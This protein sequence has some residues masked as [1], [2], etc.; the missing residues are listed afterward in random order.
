M[1]EKRSPA[2]GRVKGKIRTWNDDKGFGFIEPMLGG[3]QVFIHIK[4]L[5][6]RQ[7]RPAVG[8]VVTY[9]LSSDRQ[10]RPCAVK[11][12]LAGDKPTSKPQ[13]KRKSASTNSG[14]SRPLLVGLVFIGLVA[15][16][17]TLGKLPPLVLLLYIG[18]SLLT[19]LFYYLDKSAA[20]AGNWRTKES[21][22]H[23]MSLLG[24]WPGAWLAQQK[25]RHKSRKQPFRF[26]FWLTVLA[27]IGALVWLHTADGS[28]HLSMLLGSHSS[29]P[30]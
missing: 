3:K 12:A 29:F 15:A 8:E 7:R 23:L 18:M 21:T 4:A 28:A 9:E 11:A 14:N 24:G 20:R 30:F 5:G 27:N 25:L 17:V 1:S 16:S 26:I 10:G 2:A 19:Y 6:N 22:L 13:A